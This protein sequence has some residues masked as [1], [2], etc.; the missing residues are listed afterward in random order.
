MKENIKIHMLSCNSIHPLPR[1]WVFPDTSMATMT[2]FPGTSLIV[3]K[4][5]WVE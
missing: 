1:D 5:N 2:T 3:E 4:T